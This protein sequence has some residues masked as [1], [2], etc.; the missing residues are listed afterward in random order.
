M[1]QR[2]VFV[3]VI[4]FIDNVNIYKKTKYLQVWLFHAP[5]PFFF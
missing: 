4:F 3:V 5:P 2:G 1:L